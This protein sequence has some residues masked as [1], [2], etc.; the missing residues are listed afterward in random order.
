MNRS[1]IAPSA[2]CLAIARS[3]RGL[4]PAPAL[5]SMAHELRRPL[6]PSPTARIAAVKGGL[7][8]TPDQEKTVAAVEAAVRDFARC[9]STAPTPAMN[10]PRDEGRPDQKAGRSGARLHEEGRTWRNA[11]ALSVEAESPTRPTRA[12][13]SWD[14]GR[15]QPSDPDPYGDGR[16]HADSEKDVDCLSLSP[17]MHQKPHKAYESRSE[18]A[19]HLTRKTP[20]QPIGLTG[21][22][23]PEDTLGKTTPPGE[24]TLRVQRER[25]THL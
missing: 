18:S 22:K 5:V 20:S 17:T 23:R 14:D 16:R 6:P 9:G 13:R 2:P 8:L 19:P 24:D 3:H 10:A 12:T 4:C 11:A 15:T 1:H 25:G 7:K 21:R